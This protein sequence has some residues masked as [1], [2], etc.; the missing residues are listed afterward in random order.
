MEKKSMKIVIAPDSFKG[1]M[2]SLTAGT[3]IQE[4]IEK[5]IPNVETIRFSI[6][7]GGEGTIDIFYENLN[8]EYVEDIFTSPNFTKKEFRYVKFNNSAVIEAGQCAGFLFANPKNPM[9]TTSLG[10]GEQINHAIATGVKKIYIALGGSATNDAGTGLLSALGVRFFDKDNKEFIP[11]GSTLKDIV[12]I[13][14]TLLKERVKDIEC[15][16]LCDVLNPLYGENGAAY[17]YANQKGASDSE[18]VLLDEGLQHFSKI[19]ETQFS[20]DLSIIEGGGAAGGIGASCSYF[21]N[22]EIV[23]GID[24]I[25]DICNFDNALEN[26]DLVITGE[27][28]FDSKSMMG[29]TI[30]GIAKRTVKRNIPLVIFAGRN[31]LDDEELKKRYLIQEIYEVASPNQTFDE[32]KKN[33]NDDLRRKVRD[34]L[35][36]YDKV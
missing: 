33:C 11:V 6:A 4:E 29:K 2:T 16:L 36:R 20:K 15:T 9:Y 35:D 32:I 1:T 3:I 5:E 7:D 17:I 14:D 21:L 23:H 28:K 13:D 24:L 19:V 25:L 12:R 22:A 8:G 34:F 27:G 31:E 30:S 26:T 18:V 10:M